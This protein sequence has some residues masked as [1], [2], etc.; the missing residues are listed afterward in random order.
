MRGL[1]RDEGWAGQSQ[2]PVSVCSSDMN[3]GRRSCYY[4][5][6]ARQ[7]RGRE[8]QFG[9]E[10]TFNKIVSWK[11]LNYNSD[12]KVAAFLLNIVMDGVA[13]YHRELLYKKSSNLVNDQ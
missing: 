10:L 5:T 8:I 6:W 4:R 9:E 12:D 13:G 1:Y 7:T 11:T 2:S 3:K